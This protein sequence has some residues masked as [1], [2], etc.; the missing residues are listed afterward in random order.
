[1]DCWIA[2]IGLIVSRGCIP[3]HSDLPKGFVNIIPPVTY[4]T[5]SEQ[6][7]AI[8]STKHCHRAPRPEPCF[9]HYLLGQ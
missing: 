8:V 5:V 7:L 2:G 1:M 3:G 4:A 6:S 9:L